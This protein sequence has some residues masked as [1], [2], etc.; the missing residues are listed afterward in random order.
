V[1]WVQPS[2]A[3][4]LRT[5]AYAIRVL[6]ALTDKPASRAPDGAELLAVPVDATRGEPPP[7]G[8][9]GT[10]AAKVPGLGTGN[11]LRWSPSP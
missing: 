8:S 1:R 10:M 6:A 2:E 9:Y 4:D 11:S 5:P 7:D 3:V